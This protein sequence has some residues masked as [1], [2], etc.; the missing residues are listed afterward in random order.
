MVYT[1][2]IIDDGTPL[3]A[4]KWINHGSGLSEDTSWEGRGLKTWD[5]SSVLSG[6]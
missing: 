6:V 5:L 1:S 2:D 4:V 3:I